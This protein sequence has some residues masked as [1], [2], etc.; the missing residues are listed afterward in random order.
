MRA[1]AARR[2]RSCTPPRAAST[3]GSGTGSRRSG[4]VRFVEREEA[5]PK[6]LEVNGAVRRRVPG[7]VGL[8][9][10]RLDYTLR[11]HGPDKDL[12]LLYAVHETDGDTDGYAL[13]RI[14][15]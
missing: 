4:S 14:R 2:S 10:T 5:V 7:M 9:R 3:A 15:H 12:P 13:Y 1:N 8:D 6:I 11:E